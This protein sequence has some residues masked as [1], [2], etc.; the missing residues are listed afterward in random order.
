[1]TTLSTVITS[2][3]SR[4][5]VYGRRSSAGWSVRRVSTAG[6]APLDHIKQKSKAIQYALDAAAETPGTYHVKRREKS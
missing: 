6:T 5:E 1:M 2:G 3:R 4:I